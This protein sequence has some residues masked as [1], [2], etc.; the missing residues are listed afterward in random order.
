MRQPYH[1]LCVPICSSPTKPCSV[2]LSCL[3]AS[4]S[5]WGSVPL[6]ASAQTGPVFPVLPA[7]EKPF[8]T[9]AL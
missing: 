6:H 7:V 3:S 5:H 1:I 4:H 8:F 9:T 2:T